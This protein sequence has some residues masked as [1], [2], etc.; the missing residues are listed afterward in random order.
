MPI[1]YYNQYY[2]RFEFEAVIP[3]GTVPERIRFLAKEL[4][5]LQKTVLESVYQ[6]AKNQTGAVFSFGIGIG[7]AGATPI[8]GTPW[9]RF[10]TIQEVITMIEPFF[11]SKADLLDLAVVTIRVEM[12]NPTP[13]KPRYK[14]GA[15]EGIIRYPQEG[16][17]V[18]AGYEEE[19]TTIYK[20]KQV[21]YQDLPPRQRFS[22]NMVPPTIL[23][24]SSY[25][26]DRWEGVDKMYLT[27]YDER[28]K[29]PLEIDTTQ[30][31]AYELLS[32]NEKFLYKKSI[33]LRYLKDKIV[34]MNPET[35]TLNCF[36]MAV[37][38]AECVQYT[39]EEGLIREIQKVGGDSIAFEEKER[40]WSQPGSFIFWE[41][42]Q[43]NYSFAS[44][45]EDNQVWIRLFNTYY[46]ENVSVREKYFWEL[47]AYELEEWMRKDH[48]LVED[49]FL[50]VN[51]LENIGQNT[52]NFLE[53]CIFIYD[54]EQ[55]GKKVWAFTP[56]NRNLHEQI[57]LEKGFK[58]IS[59][60]YDHG[61]MY[62]IINIRK[63]LNQ[64]VETP[65]GWYGFCPICGECGTK[66]MRNVTTA[67]NH[68]N[69]CIAKAPVGETGF[70]CATKGDYITSALQENYNPTYE[71]FDNQVKYKVTKCTYCHERVNTSR[72]LFFHD[73]KI[74]PK[75]K[76]QL[77]KKH[78]NE[79]LF[80]YDLEAAQETVPNT[81]NTF[82]HVCN[83]VC[84]KG[85]Y[86]D[87]D[88]IFH[89]PGEY[90]FVQFL[91]TDA[92]MKDSVLL[93][94]NG[95]SYDGHFIVR[96]LERLNI[97]HTFTPS[98][99]SMHKY[100]S[101]HI[102]EPNITFLDFIYF[103]PGSLKNIA[104]SMG[105]E[106]VKGDFPHRFN[107][108]IHEQYIGAVP[109]IEEE[110]NDYWCLKTKKSV[111]DKAEVIAFYHE[112]CTTHC[113]CKECVLDVFAKK[114][115]ICGKNGW[116]MKKELFYYCDMDV[117][118]LAL[119]ARK[120]RDELL[121][122]DKENIAEADWKACAIDPYYFMTIPQLALQIELGGFESP[123]FFNALNR[124]RKGQ[125][126]ETIAWLEKIATEENTL[127]YHRNNWIREYYDIEIGRYAD[128]YNP[129]TKQMYVCL[130]CDWYPCEK[131]C[132]VEIHLA[133]HLEHPKYKGWNYAQA[134]ELTEAL[135][136][137]W[138]TRNAIV[139]H[140][141][142]IP[143]EE[144]PYIRE[145]MEGSR[146]EEYFK[147]GR[148][149]VF[150]P[151]VNVEKLEGKEI[152]Y[153]D[154]C[155]LYPYVCAFRTL[156]YGLPQY[157]PG[158]NIDPE[159]LFHTDEKW[160]YWGYM[161]CKVKPNPK[162][163]LG[164]L[165]I[166]DENQR[167]LF[168]V[169]EMK[170]CWGL[171]ELELAWK[172]GYEILEIYEIIHW[173]PENRSDKFFRGYVDF[174]LRMKQEAEGWKKLG[175][176]ENPT[177]EEKVQIQQQIFHE[178]GEI[179]L[180]R[181]DRVKK[182]PLKRLVAKLYLNS[183]WGKYGQKRKTKSHCTLY[184][185]QQ[186]HQLWFDK[187]IKNE[188]C[189]FREVGKNIFKVE[190]EMVE[191]FVKSNARGNIYL[192]AKVTEHARCILHT[193]CLLVHPE[194]VIYTDTDSVILLRE[195]GAEDITGTGLGKWTIEYEGKKIRKFYALAP[196]CYFL[197]VEGEEQL[198][199][200]AKG[201]Q[202]TIT[203]K[204]RFYETKLQ[205]LLSNPED[206]PT[207]NVD[208][209]TI[210]AN[211]QQNLGIQYGVL[212]SRYGEKKVRL[213]ISKRVMEVLENYDWSTISMIHTY[214]LGYSNN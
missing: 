179:G 104:I 160:K 20:G 51:D 182:N 103:M 108:K 175:K 96:I 203:N 78:A 102:E 109:S 106:V 197:L 37:I 125:R 204:E 21:T 193:R 64:D 214:P 211:C 162:C 32:E 80:V 130:D 149:E 8:Q 157:I 112:L 198:Q 167:L 101:I 14:R 189:L 107:K 178:N 127:I 45:L 7:D 57:H 161:R 26:R 147:G 142:Q 207:I 183:L 72:D 3:R 94:H 146:M 79:K 153:H 186:F 177:A 84:V 151:Y 13:S 128:G 61:H 10:L 98:P 150:K 62:P 17:P 163:K 52:A 114:C 199:M 124:D 131:C 25:I 201:I 15:Q 81:E 188:T 135:H 166:R 18:V 122:L 99:N 145:C 12:V 165:P 159:R 105:L 132:Q 23:K 42:L 185:F 171:D 169:F 1:R 180:I 22:S 111:E 35:N 65:I 73:C 33:E 24:R 83:C 110:V 155:S 152:L 28:E 54:V 126:I 55:Q 11:Q 148:T 19:I 60:L 90:E 97:P 156:P 43:E 208:Y 30:C 143:F 202:L 158:Y 92:R 69:K 50:N 138:G 100:L 82:Y 194:N 46:T 49:R 29:P 67:K 195:I 121:E 34:I 74:I 187:R 170:G 16:G 113:D 213:V 117:K 85:M 95:G 210:Y 209:M 192:A 144:S 212:L 181:I 68:I 164:L 36:L 184:S 118:V 38:R 9:G 66:I 63:Y 41:E 119:A 196:K 173:K 56:E 40:E 205:E 59:L 139:T 133:T 116:D 4:F 154:V 91:L 27:E 190:Y 89:F 134:Y 86:D 191:S 129:I 140:S 123:K 70:P 88:L 93:A 76:E 71:I 5:H 31:G 6:N 47:A 2:Y 115:R 176:K 206:C 39:I 174:F 200:K 120:Y 75:K 48:E 172:N 77:S 87:S 58:M 44:I 141:C 137:L 53:V 168:P 136:Y